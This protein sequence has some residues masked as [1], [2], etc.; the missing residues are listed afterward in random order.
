MSACRYRRSS[1]FWF[2]RLLIAKRKKDKEV[3][4]MDKSAKE[5]LLKQMEL[6]QEKSILVSIL[7]KDYKDSDKLLFG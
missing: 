1:V 3:N 6:L 5:I 7:S 4:S 2:R